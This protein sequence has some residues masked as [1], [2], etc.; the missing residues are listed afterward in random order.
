MT[1]ILAPPITRADRLM[2]RTCSPKPVLRS[3]EDWDKLWHRTPYLLINRHQQ[4]P[5]RKYHI[6]SAIFTSVKKYKEW[7]GLTGKYF[8]MKASS[9]CEE[10]IPKK[11]LHTIGIKDKDGIWKAR[12]RLIRSSPCTP[13]PQHN[14]GTFPDRISQPAGLVYSPVCTQQSS[15]CSIPDPPI[16]HFP[17]TLERL[18]QALPQVWSH[19][20]LSSHI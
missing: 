7:S 9:E 14:R 17:Q 4:W 20:G 10:F 13:S 2:E 18:P 5:T 1:S 12:H 6:I 11:T 19:P 8:M 15:T 3:P 16:H